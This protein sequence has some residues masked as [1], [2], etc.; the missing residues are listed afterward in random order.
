M[1]DLRGQARSTWKT[2]VEKVTSKM[3]VKSI[4]DN[5]NCDHSVC[6]A[7]CDHI[8]VSC[9]S[10]RTL[11]EYEGKRGCGVVS[12]CPECNFKEFLCC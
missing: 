7:S 10:C 1:Y 6:S 8:W 12:T 2:N 9:N 4:C 5:P 3:S 11:F